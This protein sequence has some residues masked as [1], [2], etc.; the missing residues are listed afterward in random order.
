MLTPIQA[1]IDDLLAEIDRLSPLAEAE[2]L[3][4][5]AGIENPWK[6]SVEALTR[7]QA[8]RDRLVEQ[9]KAEAFADEVTRYRDSLERRDACATELATLDAKIAAFPDSERT[10]FARA[11][12]IARWT[13]RATGAMPY[14]AFPSS[15]AQ[16]DAFGN[17]LDVPP[18]DHNH[19]AVVPAENWEAVKQLREIYIERA[20][21]G[22]SLVT[23]ENGLR[24]IVSKNPALAFVKPRQRV[25]A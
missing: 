11:N 12:E 15:D 8:D 25:A 17:V 16:R 1:K 14:A 24:D 3:A 23:M 18:R 19:K 6:G 7:A 10:L 21:V 9:R 22:Q 5:A 20:T 4:N 2:R 13:Q